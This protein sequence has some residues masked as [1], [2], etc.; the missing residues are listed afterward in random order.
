MNSICDLNKRPISEKPC[1]IP[2]EL[3]C[4]T[5]KTSYWSNVTHNQFDPFTLTATKLLF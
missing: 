3:K 1:E 4:G 2:N 5:W